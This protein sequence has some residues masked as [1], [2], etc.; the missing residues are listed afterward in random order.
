MKPRDS[1]KSKSSS[2]SSSVPKKN[3]FSDKKK[4]HKRRNVFDLTGVDGED[5][6]MSDLPSQISSKGELDIDNLDV[7]RKSFVPSARHSLVQYQQHN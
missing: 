4:K 6:Q 2:T 5:S 1:M 7:R 3:I